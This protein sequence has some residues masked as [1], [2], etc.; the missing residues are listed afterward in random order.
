[1]AVRGSRCSRKRR[2]AGYGTRRRKASRVSEARCV[3]SAAR[4]RGS[5]CQ[6]CGVGAVR[7]CRRVRQ[8]IVSAKVISAHARPKKPARARAWESRATP[9]GEGDHEAQPVVGL[10][11]PPLLE[12]GDA[13]H[14]AIRRRRRRL[15]LVPRTPVRVPT[16]WRRERSVG[17]AQAL[18]LGNRGIQRVLVT[19][20]RLQRLTGGI[21]SVESAQ[22]LGHASG[23][24]RRADRGV[25][26]CGGSVNP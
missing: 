2:S 13:V 22:G 3:R 6:S 18:E 14:A 11:F 26:R 12:A 5:R 25:A 20:G 9:T 15:C 19:T 23:R 10:P 1:M 17:R 24:A 21:F 7:F 16:G 4:G 8:G